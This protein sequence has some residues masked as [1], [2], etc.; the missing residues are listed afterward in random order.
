[1]KPLELLGQSLSRDG[2][3]LKL[4]RRGDEYIILANG[5]SLM[6]SRMHGSEEALA[7][8]ACRRAQTQQQ[9][10]ILIGGLG[11]GFTLRATL[12]LLPLGAIVTVTEIVPAVVEWNRGPLGPLARNPLQDPRVRIEIDDVAITLGLRPG[13]FDAVL[14]DVDNGPAAFA[15]SNNA[16]LYDDRGIAVARA[17]LKMDGVLAVWSAREDRKFEQRMRHGRFA[18]EVERVRG[19][20]KNGGPRHTIFLGH[21]S[22]GM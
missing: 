10:S 1:M 19:R 2:T 17:A 21:K 3:V 4:I 16:G 11:M 6:S 9:P 12:D 15:G 13:Q 22:P 5:K 8:F 18:V 20:V 14:L 7:T